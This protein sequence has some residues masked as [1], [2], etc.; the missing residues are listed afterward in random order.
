L[1]K[2]VFPVFVFPII[3]TRIIVEL[4]ESLRS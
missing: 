4:A 2:V 3:P 1:K